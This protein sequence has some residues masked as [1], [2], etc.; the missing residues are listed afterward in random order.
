VSGSAR[1]RSSSSPGGLSHLGQLGAQ[2]ADQAGIL[3]GEARLQHLALLVPPRVGG[4]AGAD[5]QPAGTVPFDF[6]PGRARRR[7]VQER[8]ET[9]GHLGGQTAPGIARRV[10]QRV[11]QPLVLCPGQ[12]GG[13]AAACRH[14]REL[15]AECLDPP[16][17][18][19]AAQL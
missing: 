15:A 4:V 12:V 10:V 19:A 6:C 13:V 3:F 1:S 14:R 16:G 9:A 18:L 5:G 2:G 7:L 17:R 11:Q 8:R